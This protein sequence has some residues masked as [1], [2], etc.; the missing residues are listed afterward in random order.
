MKAIVVNR[1]GG[2]EVLE[3]ID[4]TVPEVQPNEV[5]IQVKATSVNFADI[6]ARKGNKGGEV[7][8][9]PGIDAAGVVVKVGKKVK[10]FS[11]GQRVIAFPDKGSY[12][13]YIVADEKLTFAIPESISFEVAAASPIVSFLSYHLIKNIA[14][15]VPGESILIHAAAGE[16]GTTAIQFA[17][18]LG[19]K[20]IIGTVSD[21]YK[22]PIALEAGA[23]EVISY[24]DFAK[25]TNHFTNGLG[26]D[27]ILDSVAGHVTEES[28]NCLAP[29]GRLVQFGN[30][31]GE[32]GNIKTN[33]LHSSCRSVLGFSLGTTRKNRPEI[34][35]EIAKDIFQYLEDGLVNVQVS[36]RFHLQDAM[37]AHQL[38]E[39][40]KSTGKIL[41]IVETS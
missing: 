6:K 13:E 24:D 21:L 12:A 20:K 8:F 10:Q 5:L 33:D 25:V 31:S 9:I 40:R 37:K 30:A 19:A 3:F 15:M 39:S 34:L 1:L 32:G 7:P 26:V 18:A 35:A 27:I 38:M 17:K 29:Y 41:L 23:D 28:F 16:V 11:V 36:E 2:P 14:R 22:A 4:A